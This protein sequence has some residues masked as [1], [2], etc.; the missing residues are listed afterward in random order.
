M[1]DSEAGFSVL[2]QL[3]DKRI[4]RAVLD[5]TS[6]RQRVR[7]VVN[8]APCLNLKF[9]TYANIMVTDC[10]SLYM[11]FLKKSLLIIKRNLHTQRQY[12]PG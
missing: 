12:T 9:A 1:H 5:A 11:T 10:D 7:A 4:R 8:C 6:N 3:T 2:E